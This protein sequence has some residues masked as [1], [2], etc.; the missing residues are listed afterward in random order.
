MKPIA[1]M[2]RFI[3][4]HS[5]L[6]AFA[7]ACLPVA[8]HASPAPGLNLSL[9]CPSGR[10]MWVSVPA[11]PPIFGV[12]IKFASTK[13]V[14]ERIAAT[15][16]RNGEVVDPKYTNSARVVV[17][18]VHDQR[19]FVVIPPGVTVHQGEDISFSPGHGDPANLCLYVPN[20]MLR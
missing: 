4:R 1:S 3:N 12:I 7:I 19:W 8:A 9:T 11:K 20:L 17:Q 14:R 15:E 2:A 13:A 6:G 10:P 18:D 5:F 16:L